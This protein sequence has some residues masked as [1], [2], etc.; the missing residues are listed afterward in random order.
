MTKL[1]HGAGLTATVLSTLILGACGDDAR[2]PTSPTSPTRTAQTEAAH[3]DGRQGAHQP[4]TTTAALTGS[5]DTL[6][7]ANSRANS[8]IQNPS[9]PA[10]GPIPNFDAYLDSRNRVAMS[11]TPP[12]DTTNVIGYAAFLDWTVL[13]D[14]IPTAEVCESGTCTWTWGWKPNG[15]YNLGI[16]AVSQW[17][18]GPGS[19]ETLAV[20]VHLPDYV[21]QMQAVQLPTSGAPYKAKVT[22]R[23]P[24]R[25]G[26]PDCR[27]PPRDA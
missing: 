27:P 25:N 24:L 4:T 26:Q 7:A 6:G 1:G 22:W 13:D 10:P 2:S 21:E 17:G 23:M 9:G 12:E 18:D 3:Y 14:H 11:W 16:A 19:R 5:N 8:I 20:N 15:T